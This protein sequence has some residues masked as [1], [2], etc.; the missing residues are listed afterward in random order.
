MRHPTLDSGGEH[1]KVLWCFPLPHHVHVSQTVPKVPDTVTLNVQPGNQA[2]EVMLHVS[3]NGLL[4]PHQNPKNKVRLLLDA[5]C[6]VRPLWTA[7]PGSLVFDYF[8]LVLHH[9][10]TFVYCLHVDF[11]FSLESNTLERNPVTAFSLLPQGRIGA[12]IRSLAPL[13]EVL[14][15][16]GRSQVSKFL[17]DFFQPI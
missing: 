15:R 9:S 12:A 16:L 6:R 2:R 7:D 11:R 17:A 4:C 5:G 8:C 13:T 3:P 14:L 10:T 1:C